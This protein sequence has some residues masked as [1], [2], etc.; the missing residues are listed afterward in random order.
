MRKL[1]V[2]IQTSLDG[3]FTD[4]H[5]DMS[6]AHKQDPE[7]NAFA[8]DNA[9]GGGALLFGRVT[10]EMMAGFWSTSDAHRMNPV[11][12]EEMNS[13]P[14]LV[15][16]RKL[17]RADWQNTTLLKGD[18][19]QEV[20]KLKQQAGPDLVI[21]GSGSLIAQL[22][23]ARLIDEYQLVVNGLVLGSGRSPFEGVTSR[24]PLKLERSRAFGNGNVVLWYR[25]VE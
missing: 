6:W 5:G 2:F 1:S 8:A 14:K 25:P 18:L 13:R 10:Y 20:R 21:L 16:S 3:Y 7:W 17:E 12:A 4:S 11:V 23:Q 19:V 22:T 24:L 15:I 9:S